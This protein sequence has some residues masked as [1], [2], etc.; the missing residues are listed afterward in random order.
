VRPEPV[1]PAPALLRHPLLALFIVLVCTGAGVAAGLER[2]PSYNAE[3][4]MAVGNIDVE[5]QALPG[6]VSAV[7]SLAGSYSRA[8]DS[9]QV[10]GPVAEELGLPESE[11][12]RRISASPVPSSAVI[13]IDATGSD[14]ES[15]VRLANAAADG[16]RDY[17]RGLDS[18]KSSSNGIL[19][20]YR[21]ASEDAEQAKQK[22]ERAREAAGANSTSKK[23]QEA[24]ADY[25]AAQLKVRSLAN[26]YQQSLQQR[27]PANFTQDLT[28]ATTAASDQRSQLQLRAFTGFVAGLVLATAIV[29]ALAN[30]RRRRV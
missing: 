1:G 16:L 24:E 5:S 15:T 4:R 8:I 2:P 19:R 9:K 17:V 20:D 26:Q 22:R 23:V 27:P 14:E 12:A 21:R 25:S 3:A 13:R 28:D 10:V 6:Y 30:R 7:Q 18:G 29:T 11:V